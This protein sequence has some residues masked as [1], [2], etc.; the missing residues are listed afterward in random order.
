[1]A[2]TVNIELSKDLIKPIIETKIKGAMIEALGNT[3]DLINAVVHQTLFSKVDSTGK[4]TTGY[5]AQSYIDWMLRDSITQVCREAVREILQ[6]KREE[7]K[8]A[9]M[10][11]LDK[12]AT[13]DAMAKAM[14]EGLVGATKT[15]WRIATEFRF[16][17]K[18]ESF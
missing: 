10:K 13:Q 7:L 12:K 8:A 18:D 16:D 2:D 9:V 6:E 3:P 17:N 5:N 11:Q 15:S 1:M 4:P 14:L